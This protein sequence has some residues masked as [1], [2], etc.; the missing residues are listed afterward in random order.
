MNVLGI[1][2][3]HN[4]SACL[5]SNG[6]IKYFIE[7]ERLNRTKHEGISYLSLL[8]SKRYVPA[9]DKMGISGFFPCTEVEINEKHPFYVLVGN[10]IFDKEFEYYDY[11][12]DHHLT[13]AAGAFYNSGFKKAISIVLDGAGSRDKNNENIEESYS[14][15][16]FQYPN[17]IKVLEKTWHDKSK[18]HSRANKKSLGK[19]YSSLTEHLGFKGE[20][21]CGKTMGLSSYGKLINIDGLFEAKDLKLN[22]EHPLYKESKG[23]KN[24]KVSSDIARSL[25]EYVQKEC[26]EIILNNVKKSKCKN[27]CL[28]GGFI[29]NCVSNYYV[30]KNLPKNINLYVEPIAHDAGTSIG[31]AKLLYHTFTKST[32]IRKQESTYYGPKY[33]IDLTFPQ[34]EKYKIK[35]VTYNDVAKILKDNKTVAIYQGKSEQGPRALGNRSILFNPCNSK[36]KDKINKIKKREF[37]RPFAGTILFEKAKQYFD[38]AG[39]EESPFMCYALPVKTKKLPGITHVDNTCRVQTLKQNFN[40]HYYNLIKAFNKITG[41]PVLLNTS[42][43]LSGEPMVETLD[44]ALK[45]FKKSKIDYLYLPEIERIIVK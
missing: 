33:S 2:R 27:V 12:Y 30:R 39:L 42:F 29:L 5:I 20:Y 11:G 15:F 36:A 35:K 17:K 32:K 9:I 14:S 34:Y 40:F 31:A 44:D 8:E 24:F 13:H 7:E 28:S 26:L 41:V 38:M 43:N 19:L 18:K 3:H 6:K 1:S 21:D 10:R 16:L 45:T 37:F 23:L 22:A 4:A 25:Q